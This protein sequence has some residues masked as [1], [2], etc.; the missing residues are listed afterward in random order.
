MNR[1]AELS[2]D[3]EA[4][5]RKPSVSDLGQEAEF[6]ILQQWQEQAL[7]PLKEDVVEWLNLTLGTCDLV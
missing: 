6:D 7:E 3:P 1:P 2:Q 4:V 5:K